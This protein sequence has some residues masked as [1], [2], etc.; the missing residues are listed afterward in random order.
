MG[1]TID[2]RRVGRVSFALTL[3]FALGACAGPGGSGA[4]ALI[5]TAPGAGIPGQSPSRALAGASAGVPWGG[6]VVSGAKDETAVRCHFGKGDIIMVSVEDAEDPWRE[7]VNAC[8]DSG[9]RPI[10]PWK[11]QRKN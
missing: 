10:G 8:L 2:G 7:A 1:G 11:S 5:P 6:A 4:G 9:G 3:A